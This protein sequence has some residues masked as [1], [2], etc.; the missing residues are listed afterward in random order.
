MHR[1]DYRRR[2]SGHRTFSERVSE[3]SEYAVC[4]YVKLPWP[5]NSKRTMWLTHTRPLRAWSS[6]SLNSTGSTA[7]PLRN[8]RSVRCEGHVAAAVRRVDPA[9]PSA[10]R[11]ARRLERATRQA[12]IRDQVLPPFKILGEQTDA[13]VRRYV[14]VEHQGEFRAQLRGAMKG[15]IAQ[16]ASGRELPRNDR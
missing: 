10:R 2:R 14:P 16:V 5:D 15:T 9:T 7:A 8:P 13:L 3:F 6:F 1:R 11:G 4:L 12:L